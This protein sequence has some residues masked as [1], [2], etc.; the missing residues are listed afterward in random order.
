MGK[1]GPARDGH[2]R[3][4]LASRLHVDDRG[5][6]DASDAVKRRR[7]LSSLEI[8]V[9]IAL[10]DRLGRDYVHLLASSLAFQDAPIR[11]LVA[12]LQDEPLTMGWVSAQVRRGYRA[13]SEGNEYTREGK[14]CGLLGHVLLSMTLRKYRLRCRVKGPFKL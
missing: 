11:R 13:A 9:Q 10:D 7:D 4:R 14:V 2:F 1:P 5:C 8:R 6:L 12:L 3:G